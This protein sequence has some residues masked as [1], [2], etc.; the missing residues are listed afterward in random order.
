LVVCNRATTCSKKAYRVLS[1][2]LPLVSR[3]GTSPFQVIDSLDGQELKEPYQRDL[4]MSATATL[5]QSWIDRLNCRDDSALHEMISHVYERLRRLT[6]HMF[7]D[8]PLPRSWESLDD[9]LHNAYARLHAA[10]ADI[11]FASVRDVL[12][13][14]AL[15]LRRELLELAR[16]YLGPESAASWHVGSEALAPTGSRSRSASRKVSTSKKRSRRFPWSDFHARAEWLRGSERE[17]FDL[18]WYHGMTQ[19][20]AAA[21][22]DVS[23]SAIRGYWLSARRFLQAGLNGAMPDRCPC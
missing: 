3:Q 23:V 21:V 8:L 6:R 12:R 15:Q 13:A 7:R 5:F 1:P 4:H 20:E 14:V 19:S 16:F 17:V 22:L 10:L 9:A 2:S 11:H 18:L